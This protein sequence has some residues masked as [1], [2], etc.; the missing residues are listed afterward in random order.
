MDPAVLTMLESFAKGASVIY[1]LVFALFG[2]YK[3][4]WVFGWQY[5]AAMDRANAQLSATQKE[6]SFHRDHYEQAMN[7]IE[8]MLKVVESKP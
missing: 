4:W 7:Q 6:C 1:L 8:R 2:G 3:G 5:T